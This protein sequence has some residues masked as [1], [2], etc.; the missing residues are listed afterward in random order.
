MDL[1][2]EGTGKKFAMKRI[3]CHSQEDERNA[4]QEAEFHG[5]FNHTNLIGLEEWKSTKLSSEITEV[6]LILPYYRVSISG[7]LGRGR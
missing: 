4:K 6:Q 1:V 7:W 2:E 3:Q 5:K